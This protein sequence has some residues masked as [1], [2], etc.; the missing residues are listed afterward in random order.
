MPEGNP[1]DLPAETRFVDGWRIPQPDQVFY[2]RDEAFEVPAQ[3]TVDYKHFVVDPEWD[4]D[5]YIYA[6]EARPD[7]TSVVHH[8][9]VYVLPPGQRRNADLRSV[10]V[11][12]AP[13]S[14]PVVLEDGLAIRVPAGSKLLF[15]LHYTPN[16][17]EQLDRS[18]A[19]VCFTDKKDVT[20][21]LNGRIAIK[22]DFEIPPQAENCV[23]T[24]ECKLRKD[25]MLLSMTPHLHLRGTSFRYEAVYPDGSREVLLDVPDYDFNWQLKYRLAEPKLLPKGTTVLCTAT[26]DNSE[27]NPVNPDPNKTVRWGDQ[28]WEEMMI[29]FFDTI[30]AESKTERLRSSNVQIDPSGTW[31]WERAFAGRTSK[32]TLTLTLNDDVLAGVLET[33]GQKV[34]IQDAQVTGDRLTFQVALNQFGGVVLDFDAKVSEDKL[35]GSVTFSIEAIGNQ[36]EFPWKASRSE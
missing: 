21:L 20:K 1:A 35:I 2:M 10:L 34:E 9:L 32:E 29:G 16:G 33:N 13:G 3:G 8:I 5:K 26:Y 6:A 19:G 15:Q 22:T 30:P 17:R 23:V 31:S 28:S 14:T 27:G 7:N 12:Y 18:Y 4:E 24:A 11:G 25:E 36:R